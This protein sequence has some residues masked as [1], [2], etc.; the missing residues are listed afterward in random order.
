[1]VI[2]GKGHEAYQVFADKTVHF[3]D[4]EAAKAIAPE[5]GRYWNRGERCVNYTLGEIANHRWKADS[6]GPGIP[7]VGVAIDSRKDVSEPCSAPY[8][9]RGRT[10]MISWMSWPKRA[11]GALVQRP[12]ATASPLSA[13]Y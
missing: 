13:L 11:V 1:M 2:A 4:F 8:R 6:G 5:A 10:A 3:D 12:V 9:D 7:F